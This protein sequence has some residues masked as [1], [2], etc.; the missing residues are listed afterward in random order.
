MTLTDNNLINNQTTEVG[1]H[2]ANLNSDRS[3][4]SVRLRHQASIGR[5]PARMRESQQELDGDIH[6]ESDDHDQP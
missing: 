3:N 4:P 2:H 5:R 6:Q 1:D